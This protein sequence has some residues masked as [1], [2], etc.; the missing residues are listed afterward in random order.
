[1]A[2]QLLMQPFRCNSNIHKEPEFVGGP[3]HLHWKETA[4]QT[5]KIGDLVYLDASLG[6]VS[7]C[8]TTGV[9]LNSAILGQARKNA[10]GVTGDPVHIAVI[11][12]DEKFIMNVWHVTAGSAITA[13]SQLGTVR[14]IILNSSKWHV[15]INNSV[16]GSANALAR[17]QIVDFPDQGPNGAKNT[18]GDTYGW[19]TVKFLPFSLSLTGTLAAQRILQG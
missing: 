11:R 17:V 8:T 2:T 14:G 9:Q 7:I 15:D 6:T 13:Q 1:M 10:T 19:V 16:E 18:I 3:E 12:P 4:S 5:F